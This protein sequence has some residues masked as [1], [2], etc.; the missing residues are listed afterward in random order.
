MFEFLYQR[1]AMERTALTRRVKQE[2]FA[3]TRL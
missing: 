3:E 2:M 1:R